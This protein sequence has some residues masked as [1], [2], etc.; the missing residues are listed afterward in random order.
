MSEL[1]LDPVPHWIV[2][3]GLA[4]LLAWSAVHKLR[5]VAAFRGALE[6]YAL[7]PALWVVPAGAALIAVEIGLAVAL[8]LP[9][10]GA[11][12]AV[13]TAALLALYGA[14][15]AVNLGRG[16]RDIDCGCGGPAGAQPIGAGLVA[17]NALLAAAALAG[18]L[19]AGPRALTWVDGFTIAAAVPALGLLYVAIDGLMRTHG[20]GLRAD[21]AV[22]A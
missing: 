10:V 19:P 6:G 3:G 4:L 15:M 12:A 16:R 21:P 17:R 9:P 1:A 8:C 14:A 18:A 2:R 22:T 13:A 11:A 7:L 20:R 5:D